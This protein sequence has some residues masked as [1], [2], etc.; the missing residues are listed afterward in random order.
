MTSLQFRDYL[1][2]QTSEDV[3]GFF[4]GWVFNG[5]FPDYRIDSVKLAGVH[6]D[7]QANVYITQKLNH[8]PNQFTEIPLE[9]GVYNNNFEL[10]TFSVM[11]GT[12]QSFVII[13]VGDVPKMIT[14]NPNN[15]L[16]YATTDDVK[17]I[18]QIGTLN[19]K[20]AMM[21]VDVKSINDSAL[22][23]IEHHWSAPDGIKNWATK[24]YLLSNYR[25]WKVDGILPAGFDASASFMYDGRENGGYLDSLLV[26]VTE[27]SLVL[28]YRV[29]A[30]DDWLEYP[31]YIKNTLGSSSNKYGRMELSKLL[32]GEYTL[33]NIDH[34]VLSTGSIEQPKNKL[35][36]YPNPSNEKVTLEWD[37]AQ[38]AIKIEIFSLGGKKV[39]SFSKNNYQELSFN[40]KTISSGQY[41]AKVTFANEV[42]T[43]QFIINH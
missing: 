11:V 25:Y 17:I 36:I 34:S 24:P 41:I 10:E 43:Q 14:L 16:C 32:L 35:K 27:D 2:T 33:A 18:K 42:I 1:Q 8:A 23:K 9:I 19:Y 22:L 37:I 38:T 4:D 26:N 12:N 39:L 15:K 31:H 28:L 13:D 5:G 6:P 21:L 30:K 20:N 40:S 29:D 3:T 7:L